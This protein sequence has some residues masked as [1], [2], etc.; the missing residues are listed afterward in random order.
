MLPLGYADLDFNKPKIPMTSEAV[1]SL[2]LLDR[3]SRIFYSRSRFLTP[4]WPEGS[5]I[6]CP[7]D[8]NLDNLGKNWHFWAGNILNLISLRL[9]PSKMV[10]KSQPQKIGDVI[11]ITHVMF[12]CLVLRNDQ[13][14]N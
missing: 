4:G 11:I 10:I 3:V 9:S 6:D 2:A 12:M 5:D 14:K 1:T 13:K 8:L 7:S